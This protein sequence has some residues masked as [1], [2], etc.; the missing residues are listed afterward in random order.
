MEDRRWKSPCSALHCVTSI[1]DPLSSIFSKC[2][3]KETTMPTTID[4]QPTLAT[5]LAQLEELWGHVD[6]L[7][8]PLTPADWRRK[9]GKHWV[10]ADLPYHLSYYDRETVADPI[11]K[12]TNVPAN[13]QNLM[14]TMGELDAWNARK[15]A[16]RRPG[17]SVAESLAQMRASR[18]AVRQAVADLTDADLDQRVFIHLVGCGWVTVRLALESCL[19]HTWAH[20]T[21]ARLRLK[22]DAPMP[23]PA[24]VHTSLGF[25]LGLLPMMIS[26][27]KM[28]A[29]PFTAIM[30][31]GGPGGGDWTACIANG[32]CTVT[33]QRSAN[34]DI[35]MTHRDAETFVTTMRGM[36]NPML[37]MLTGKIKVQGFRNMGTFGKLFAEP[38]PDQVLEPVFAA[39]V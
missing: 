11:R 4:T 38:K 8:D 7:L 24:I 17:Q 26:P 21:E 16:E 36:Q 30:C 14:R 34:A 35:I 39:A 37:A 28:T 1:F 18:D 20:F 3:F 32:T 33:E 10:F 6:T 23:S 13:D 27:E 29:K 5:L 2:N 9:H 25:F 19:V 22:K 15:F 31:I 12:G